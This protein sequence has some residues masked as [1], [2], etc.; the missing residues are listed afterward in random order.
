MRVAPWLAAVCIALVL[1]GIGWFAWVVAK[2]S[3]V[4][5]PEAGIV[6]VIVVLLFGRRLPEWTRRLLALAPWR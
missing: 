4:S 5:G 1:V 3:G 2:R 6:V